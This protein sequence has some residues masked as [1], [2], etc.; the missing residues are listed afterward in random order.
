MSIRG[1]KRR[2]VALNGKSSSGGNSESKL[3][4]EILS[5]CY[6]FSFRFYAKRALRGMKGARRS[7]L[8]ATFLP[9]LYDASVYFGAHADI[10]SA[11]H[12]HLEI[13][14]RAFPASRSRS[15][16]RGS[17]DERRDVG[18]NSAAAIMGARARR[19]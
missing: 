4:A 3:V 2:G 11:S 17:I 10:L 18:G 8:G 1:M 9:E 19:V 6:T 15:S 16:D 12:L 7:A 13:N 14:K 5:S